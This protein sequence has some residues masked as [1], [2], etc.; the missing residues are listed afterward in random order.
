MIRI[1]HLY[2]KEMNIYGDRG[3]VVALNARCAWRNIQSKIVFCGL[4]DKLSI[5]PGDIVFIGGGQDR[6]Q[7]RVA[8]DLET[9]ADVIRQAV[10][11]G[12]PLL[13]IC[14]GYQ[15][16]GHHF[17]PI[18]GP[19]LGGIGVFDAKTM[20]GSERMIGNIVVES[21]H[22]GR[23]VGFENHSGQ[24]ILGEKQA[25]LGV[26]RRGC[27]NNGKDQGEGAMTQHAIGTYMHGSFL[28]KNPAVTDW[29]IAAAQEQ[30][31]EPTVLKKLDDSL[32]RKASDYAA[33]LEP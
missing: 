1:I 8:A 23:L 25:E 29:L 5:A 24:T 4:G 7:S 2:P 17:R 26:V 11:S 27:G 14:G 33:R 12:T 18:E 32:E 6:G 21:K 9:K 22:F 3:N 10:E 28:P 16:L 19:E 13:A 20:G 15:L 30:L 31:G